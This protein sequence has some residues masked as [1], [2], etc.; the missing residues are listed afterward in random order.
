MH[1][2]REGSHGYLFQSHPANE[3]QHDDLWPL[4][5]RRAA[6]R[7]FDERPHALRRGDGNASRAPQRR[8]AVMWMWR[9]LWL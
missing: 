3:V 4:R 7:W 5:V 6:A 8:F 2:G 9:G 1:T